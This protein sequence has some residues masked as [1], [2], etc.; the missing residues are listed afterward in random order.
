MKKIEGIEEDELRDLHDDAKM[1]PRELAEFYEV[2][3]TTIKRRMEEYDIG[4]RSMSEACRNQAQ[5]K[6]TINKDFFK[7]WTP[8][9]AWLYGWALG[10]GSCTEGTSLRFK[11]SCI[12]KEV[13]YKFRDAINS[14]HPVKDSEE[15]KKEYQKWYCMSKIDFCSVELVEDL[16][17]LNYWD[18]PLEYFNHFVRGFFE[19]EG[20]VFWH[21]DKRTR[22]GGTIGSNFA[23]NDRN[24]L[25]FIHTVLQEMRIVRNGSVRKSRSQWLLTF[26][27][28]DSFTLYNYIYNYTCR[29]RF[30]K[31]KKEKFEELIERQEA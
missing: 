14:E 22:R 29:N 30:L 9:S 18:V 31:R 2:G 8:E 11:L 28:N 4:S 1:C 12:D 27:V 25:D 23:Q 10:D 13:L 3:I 5:R 17:K 21:K 16:N 26:S 6:Y 15:W 24:I 19:A 7:S 20:C